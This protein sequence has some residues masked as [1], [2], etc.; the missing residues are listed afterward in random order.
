MAAAAPSFWIT[1]LISP[2]VRDAAS[3]CAS[4]R[5]LTGTRKSSARRWKGWKIS[6]SSPARSTLTSPTS[7]AP[8]SCSPRAIW[9]S[10]NLRPI[11]RSPWRR[12][13]ISPVLTSNSATTSSSACMAWANRFIAKSSA[14]RSSTGP[15]V[16]MPPSAPM[17]RCWPISSAAC[18]KTARTLPSSTA[19]PIPLYQWTPCWKTRSRWSRPMPFPAH[20]MTASPRPPT[21]SARNVKTPPASIFPVKRRSLHWTIP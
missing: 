3:W 20:G 16:F 15:A 11:T 17:R 14:G 21:C 9:S 18:W 12:S 7:P 6:R 10:R 19:L 8:A 13:T 2:A 4:S 5:A 1:S